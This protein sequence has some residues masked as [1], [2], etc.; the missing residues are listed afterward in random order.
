MGMAPHDDA[1]G[2]DPPP[3]GHVLRWSDRDDVGPLQ[4]HFLQCAL[5]EETS[6]RKWWRAAIK[7]TIVASTTDLVVAEKVVACWTHLTDGTIRTSAGDQASGWRPPTLAE[8]DRDGGW[9]FVPSGVPPSFGLCDDHSGFSSDDD[10]EAS[11]AGVRGRRRSPAAGVQKRRTARKYA[12]QRTAYC[13][14]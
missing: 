3:R 12:R 8:R 4:W 11:D 13:F 2:T 10:S 6:V 9:N 1:T 14:V 5:A 7:R